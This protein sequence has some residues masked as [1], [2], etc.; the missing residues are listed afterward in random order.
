[1]A[2]TQ[3][4]VPTVGI[5]G[6]TLGGGFGH[7]HAKYGLAIDNVIG[8][9]VIT[10]DGGLLTANASENQDLFWGV[11]G[12]GARELPDGI[13]SSVSSSRP[14]RCSSGFC[15]LGCCGLCVG[16]F[17]VSTLPCLRSFVLAG[18]SQHDA[19]TMLLTASEYVYGLS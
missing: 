18:L 4:V 13:Y 11:R 8:A 3:G 1:L 9:D 6:L 2:T 5:A 7:L 12:G 10:A 19:Y 14:S 17:G 16:W 15:S